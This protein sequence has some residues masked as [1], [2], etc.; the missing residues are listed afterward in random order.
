[1]IC[2]SIQAEA[3]DNRM[4]MQMQLHGGGELSDRLADGA[5]KRDNNPYE[6]H[7]CPD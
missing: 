3:G 4:S 7:S 6:K 2:R 1:M 5:I